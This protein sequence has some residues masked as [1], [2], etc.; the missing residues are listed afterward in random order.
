[1]TI[2]RNLI[3]NFASD[4]DTALGYEKFVEYYNAYKSNKSSVGTGETEISMEDAHKK[5][6]AFFS[7]EIEKRCN[8]KVENEKDLMQYCAYTDV[9]EA[10]FAV[11]SVLT[12]L[13]I[14][15]AILK[16][17]APIAEFHNIG[18]GDTAKIV[19]KPRDLI[20]PSKIG[21]ARRMGVVRQQFAGEVTIPTY[22]REVTVGVSFYDVLIG[23]YNLAEYMAKAAAGM[24]AQ[25]RYDIWDA[26][27][28]A[29]ATF[30]NSGTAKLVYTGYTQD[31]FVNLA[32]TVGA[33]N[34][35]RAIVL[36]TKTACSKVLPASTNYRIDLD[37]SSYVRNGS[38]REF[39]GTEVIQMEQI[40]DYRTEFSVKLD[41][42]KLYFVSPAQQKII[43]VAM[44][45]NTLGVVRDNKEAANLLATGT[46]MKSWGVVAASAALAGVITVS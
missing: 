44:E 11:V 34:N 7:K 24:E 32:E 30:D 38:L 25:I 19:V 12:D 40:A 22:M 42:T 1:M 33:W 43:H 10:A 29:V 31:D 41:N 2:E 35:S 14:P 18:W 21:R 26:F 17:V 45:G 16:E 6:N 23:R 15:N 8:K 9:R 39:M 5:M 27:E 3:M 28:T 46:M 4:P 36:G 37:T 20:L 13:I